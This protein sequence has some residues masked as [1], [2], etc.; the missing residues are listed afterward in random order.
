MAHSLPNYS[1]FDLYGDPSTQGLRWKKWLR[2]F[3][4][5]MTGLNITDKTR[6][7]ALLLYYAGESLHDMFETLT[8]GNLNDDEYKQAIDALNT[9]MEPSK[10][11]DK[12]EEEFRRLTQLPGESIDS[13]HTKLMQKAQ[14]CD[15]HDVAK[16]VR[17][18]LVAG[19][20]LKHVQYKGR[21]YSR[22]KMPLHDLLVEAR[23]HELATAE[24]QQS[25][26]DQSQ[27][28]SIN[29][30]KSGCRKSFVKSDSTFGTSKRD[31]SCWF[32]GRRYPHEGK[33][34]AEGKTCTFCKKEGHFEK[35][36]HSKNN[37]KSHQSRF[38][39][40]Y[41]K[42]SYY[43]KGNT[44]PK[45][46]QHLEEREDVIS[47]G[48][49]FTLRGIEDPPTIK[50]TIGD[51]EI[52][53]MIVDSGCPKNLISESAISAFKENPK[54]IST[55][56][57]LYPYM[58]KNPLPIQGKFKSRISCNDL[59]EIV[60]MYVVKGNSAS[61]MCRTTA[62][63]LGLLNVSDQV[64]S[65]TSDPI[66]SLIQEYT[67]IFTGVGKLKNFQVKLHTDPD[68]VPVAQ[69][70]RRV[71]YSLR[72]KISDKIK[73]LED[74]EII[75]QVTGPTPW[76]SPI[77]CVPKPHNPE[78]IRI[79]VD[80][81]SVNNSILR[82]RHITPTIT[83]IIADING[84]TIFSKLDLNQ[85]YHQLELDPDSRNLTTFSTH[86]GLRQYTRLNFGISCA[87]EIFQNA[88]SQVLQ[89]I[90]GVLNVSDDIM[91]FAKS[92]EEHMTSLRSVLKRL[93]ENNLTL[94]KKKCE[95]GKSK[96]EFFGL[97]FS[98]SGVEADPKKISSLLSVKAPTSVSEVRSFMGMITY[99]S[100]FIPNMATIA[101]P[102]R[103]LTH[104]NQK[105]KWGSDE[106]S[107]FTKLK[108]CLMSAS[109]M[110]Y[111]DSKKDISLVV[112]AS[113]VGL[114]AILLQEGRVISYASRAL[115]DVE[116]RY[117]Q[118]ERESLAIYWGCDHFRLY[119]YGRPIVVIT[120]HKALVPLFNNP[121]SKPPPR[122]ERWIMKLQDY[123]LNERL[124]R[125][126]N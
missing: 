51:S 106:Q 6:K 78:D 110:A 108:H 103:M 72:Q 42:S 49:I 57:K 119:L 86:V 120:D 84:S 71:P 55:A 25:E 41:K 116:S 10:N 47:D 69:P 37:K 61:L 27:S 56:V 65:V 67:H 4:N 63:A 118:T 112:D 123:E 74:S 5:L 45:H 33:C 94:N 21:K 91:I 19:T 90:P 14:F 15:F 36:C 89:G 24:L 17:L 35:M 121:L 23:A 59:T 54:I 2:G 32:C 7:R 101:A 46:V 28:R 88:I 80:M 102:L 76:V 16:E 11:T 38:T 12:H 104:K 107:A 111:Y 48:E 60:D 115:S 114:G 62:Q 3:E 43:K 13:F 9:H 100:R 125:K 109:V 85:G 73:E 20:S 97:V 98:G 82:E 77:V 93:S 39:N 29:F 126:D 95:F 44:S 75:E 58:S 50:V 66:N 26:R 122:I 18:Q 81:R 64:C 68:V 92:Q 1:P 96:M 53:S 87:S 40:K 8:L 83:E 70:H 22:E 79:C 34:P 52:V 113:P 31:K 105:W 117:S 99:V 124:M 30:V